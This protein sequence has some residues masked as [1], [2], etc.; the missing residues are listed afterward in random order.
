[1]KDQTED[2]NPL[3]QA[4]L[5]AY[6]AR[7]NL[8]HTAVAKTKMRQLFKLVDQLDAETCDWTNLSKLHIAPAAFEIVK[9]KKIAPHKVF[10]HPGILEKHPRLIAYYRNLV[11]IS[12]KGMAQLGL[13]TSR[14]ERVKPAKMP[15][16][17]AMILCEVLNRIISNV[18]QTLPAFGLSAGRDVAFAEIGTEIQGTWANTIGKGASKAVED[19]FAAYLDELG[20]GTRDSA[21]HYTLNNGWKIVFGSEPDVKFVDASGVEQI[22]IEIK[23]SLD[24]AGAQTRY[25][26]AKKSFAK[27]SLITQGATRCIWP[28]CSRMQFWHRLRAMAKC[29]Q[30]RISH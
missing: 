22:V 6:S 20:R 3:R 13:R 4:L 25:G 23:G 26:E 21:G 30:P 7:A 12:Q 18:V 27:A 9:S 28:A 14:F 1:M 10:A 24:R 19:M 8:F 5:Q 29:G 16:E 15:T 17:I 11:A 2:D